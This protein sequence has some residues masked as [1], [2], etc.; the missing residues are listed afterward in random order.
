VTDDIRALEDRLAAVERRLSGLWTHHAA[1]DLGARADI[2]TMRLDALAAEL[3]ALRASLAGL[4]DLVAGLD[5]ST[6]WLTGIVHD[7]RHPR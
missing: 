2:A 6:E 4:A 5:A 3:A 7:L 1:A